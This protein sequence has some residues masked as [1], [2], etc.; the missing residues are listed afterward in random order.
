MSRLHIIPLSFLLS[1]HLAQ[2]QPGGGMGGAQPALPNVD[3]ESIIYQPP[4]KWYPFHKTSD[5]KVDTF[6]F[7]TG[8]KPTDWKEALQI[9]N[10]LSTLGVTSTHQVYELRTQGTGCT[11]HR[12][13]LTK[14]N[15]ENGYPMAQWTQ[16]CILADGSTLFTLAKSILGNEQLFVVS[17]IWKY[18]PKERDLTEW[19]TY[20][21]Q[22]Y[23]CDPTTERNPCRPPNG[24]AGGAGGRPPR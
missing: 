20:L 8:Q 3:K 12:A 14:E 2:A 17:K 6:Y 11:S 1:I 9:E 5:A 15:M 7:P 24:P 23:A 22:V 18:E 16:S 21:D 13:D 10:F 4:A 19:N